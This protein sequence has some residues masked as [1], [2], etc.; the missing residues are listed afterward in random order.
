[1]MMMLLLMPA[2]WASG[3]LQVDVH[4]LL[5][6]PDSDGLKV[7]E[8]IMLNNS[9]PSPVEGISFYLP[10]GYQNLSF[11]SLTAENGRLLTGPVP[12]GSHRYVFSYVLNP[13]PGPDFTITIRPQIPTALL[14]VLVPAGQIELVGSGL[15]TGETIA[16][17]NIRY[18]VYAW[19]NPALGETVSM[20]AV[21]LPGG[22]Q[23]APPPGP[24]GQDKWPPWQ[25]SLIGLLNILFLLILFFAALSFLVYRRLRA[26]AASGGAASGDADELQTREKV[27][28]NKIVELEQKRNEGT[29]SEEDYRLKREVYKQKL[30]EVKAKSMSD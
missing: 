4:H 27:L 5:L 3:G 22:E 12:P 28:L 20:T 29:V 23:A 14:V 25:G 18:Q 11:S 30:I 2:A 1:M 10:L 15:Q 17:G 7:H 9:G 26:R 19:E 13:A 24:V 6:R 8:R 16:M 21:L